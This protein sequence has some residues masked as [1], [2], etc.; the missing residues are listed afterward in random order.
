MGPVSDRQV[1]HW[2]PKAAELMR[3]LTSAFYQAARMEMGLAIRIIRLS[4]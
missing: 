3:A 2:C 4:A 1:R